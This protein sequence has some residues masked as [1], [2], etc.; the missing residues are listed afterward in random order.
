MISDSLERKPKFLCWF[1]R[2]TSWPPSSSPSL[3]TMPLGTSHTGFL[4]FPLV[5][6]VCSHFRIWRQ[7][8]FFHL[9]FSFTYFHQADFSRSFSSS[10]N[11]H[12]FRRGFPEC[13]IWRISFYL[14]PCKNLVF[15]VFIFI[16]FL[17]NT[18]HYFTLYIHLLITCLAVEQN[19]YKI[20]DHVSLS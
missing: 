17:H 5:L 14:T 20:R 19:L 10:L 4:S 18:H 8:R 6:H 2:A 16:D 15:I 1:T 7:K 12:L 9:K 13:P 3:C 11:C